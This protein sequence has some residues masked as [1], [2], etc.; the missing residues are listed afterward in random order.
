MHVLDLGKRNRKKCCV[1]LESTNAQ[2]S[3]PGIV[4]LLDAREG[5]IFPVARFEPIHHGHQS[6]RS[7]KNSKYTA[8]A[9]H[10]NG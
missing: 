2:G 4:G 10:R 5:R 8:W 9:H 7:G 1:H 3:L 6:E